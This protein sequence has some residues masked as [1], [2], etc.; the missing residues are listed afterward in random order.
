[1]STQP[2]SQDRMTDLGGIFYPVGYLVAA[3]PEEAQAQQV[4]SDLLRGG[5]EEADCVLYRAGEVVDAAKQN[6]DRHD[7][8]LSRLGSSDDAVRVHLASARKG[9]SFLLVYAPGDIEAARAMNV[10]RRVPF[11]FV[12]RYH[13]M[14]IEEM[15]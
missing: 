14:A 10:I 9:A 2:P 11:V 3:F 13:R 1:M 4:R 6:L 7:S 8:W 15:K 12:H 5:Y